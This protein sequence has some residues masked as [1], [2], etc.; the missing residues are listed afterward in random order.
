M[1]TFSN[2]TSNQINLGGIPFKQK[3]KS[4]RARF[5]AAGESPTH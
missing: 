5:C 2:Q 4:Q 3:T 1:P